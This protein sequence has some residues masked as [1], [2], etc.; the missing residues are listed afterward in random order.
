MTSLDELRRENEV[1]GQRVS[2]LRERISKLSEA[3]LRVGASLE[4]RT[5]LRE[6][7][8]SSRCSKR[9]QEAFPYRHCL[10][11]GE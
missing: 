9:E 8:E 6:I 2:R 3:I 10:S 4:V 5:V 7:V 11:R 1:L